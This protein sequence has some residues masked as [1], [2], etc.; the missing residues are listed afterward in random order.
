M[1]GRDF[2]SRSPRCYVF[3]DKREIVCGF[4][5]D[6]IVENILGIEKQGDILEIHVFS[7]RYVSGKREGRG[8]MLIWRK[9]LMG[10]YSKKI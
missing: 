3:G 4:F 1:V 8:Q 2:L 6:V 5:V 9:N 10:S 7:S